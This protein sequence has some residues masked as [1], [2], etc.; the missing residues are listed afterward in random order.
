MHQ[1]RNT[2]SYGINVTH[3]DFEILLDIYLDPFLGILCYQFE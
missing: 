3:I 1:I 2:T